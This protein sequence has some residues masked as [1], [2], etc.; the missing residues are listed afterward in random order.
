M[1]I[2]VEI[3][4][5][6]VKIL[7]RK[8]GNVSKA[9]YIRNRIFNDDYILTADLNQRLCMLEQKVNDIEKNPQYINYIRKEL[10]ELCKII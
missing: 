5:E 1:K 2:S 6:E 7:D 8:R 4:D 10:V 3:S 9:A